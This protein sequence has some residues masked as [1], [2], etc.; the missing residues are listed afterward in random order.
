MHAAKT[1]VFAA[2]KVW[3]SIHNL[4]EIEFSSNARMCSVHRV[5]LHVVH[6]KHYSRLSEGVNLFGAQ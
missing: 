2:N 3:N 6:C 4:I 1:Q 5:Y